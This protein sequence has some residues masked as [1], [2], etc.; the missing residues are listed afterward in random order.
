MNFILNLMG[1]I[2]WTFVLLW[3]LNCNSKL[4]TWRIHKFGTQKQ[5]ISHFNCQSSI[6]ERLWSFHNIGCIATQNSRT[7][8]I[9]FQMIWVYSFNSHFISDL[10]QLSI[11]VTYS[12]RINPLKGISRVFDPFISS[13]ICQKLCLACCFSSQTWR[14]GMLNVSNWWCK[15]ILTK[16]KCVCIIKYS[17]TH[18]HSDIE[19][20][21]SWSSLSIQI[22]LWHKTF[23]CL[24]RWTYI[25]TTKPPHV[26]RWYLKTGVFHPFYGCDESS[27]QC[28]TIAKTQMV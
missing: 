12:I 10:Y 20:L 14:D 3:N 28:D 5:R 21:Y 11:F 26:R 9:H 2:E 19:S 22:D 16:F 6:S 24:F 27:I 4:W 13:W 17:H 15:N 1:N 8:T 18:S 7:T 25:S 23:S